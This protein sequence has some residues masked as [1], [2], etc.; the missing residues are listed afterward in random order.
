MTADSSSETREAG[1]SDTVVFRCWRKIAASS[2]P[3]FSKIILQEWKKDDTLKKEKSKLK[4]FMATKRTLKEQIREF[5]KYK[6]NYK[7]LL[8]HQKWRKNH[9]KSK[10]MYKC[11]RLSPLIFLNLWLIF[12]SKNC[13]IIWYGS[14]YMWRSYL[15]WLYYKLGRVEGYKG[16]SF[17][18][19]LKL[20]MCWHQ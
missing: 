3:Y 9:R 15:G 2:K 4:E 18:T 19:S 1:G 20:T 5:L 8:E 14:Q 6:K 10:I 12:W 17:Y 7:G 11:T 13:N 16:G